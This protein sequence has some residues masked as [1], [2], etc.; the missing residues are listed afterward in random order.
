MA[1]FDRKFN[2]DSL[3]GTFPS[4]IERLSGT[5]IRL[6]QKLA[7]IP[8]KFLTV[9]LDERWSIQENVGHLLDLEPLWFG[10]FQDFVSG[11][12]VLR[13]AD[14]TNAKTNHADHNRTSLTNLL[15]SFKTRR[16][17]I[18]HFIEPLTQ[19][20]ERLASLHPRLMQPMR[21]IDLGYFIAEHDDHHLAQITTLW[22]TLEDQ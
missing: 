17:E 7:N 6:E 15:T 1:W 16:E 12:S 21:L 9:R 18:I 5:P 4:I 22:H 8:A 19:E 2:F 13:E 10:R 20:A 14:L 3:A 11:V